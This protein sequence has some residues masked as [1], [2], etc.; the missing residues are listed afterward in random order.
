MNQVT[1]FV[2]E[3]RLIFQG[4]NVPEIKKI[5]QHYLLFSHF[6]LALPLYLPTLLPP[7][8]GCLDVFLTN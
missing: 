1:D 4:M 6:I 7:L 5:V 2:G 3:L 8:V